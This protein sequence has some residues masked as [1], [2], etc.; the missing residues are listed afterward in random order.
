MTKEINNMLCLNRFFNLQQGTLCSY[1]VLYIFM[2]NFNISG[3]LNKGYLNQ[4]YVK[5][6]YLILLI[7]DIQIIIYLDTGLIILL[8]FYLLRILLQKFWRLFDHKKT[9]KVETKYLL[10]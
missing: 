9:F 10:S 8:G 7:W 6:G 2:L 3:Y 5:V 1:I 4:G